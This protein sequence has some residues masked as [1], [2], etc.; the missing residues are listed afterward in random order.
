M[1]ERS[2]PREVDPHAPGGGDAAPVGAPEPPEPDGAGPETRVEVLD[3][4]ADRTEERP[5]A[6]H[7]AAADPT[8]GGER[9][10]GVSVA[11]NVLEW[12]TILGGALVVA[13]V[14]TRF[15]V[16]AFFIPSLSMYPAL[17]EGDRV[18]V[19]KL[20][21]RLHEINRGDLIVFERP[22]EETPGQVK[23]LIKR[24][25]ALEGERIEARGGQVLVDGEPLAEPYL[26]PGERTTNLEPLVVPEGHV[27]VMGDNRQDSRDS[28]F[29]GPLPEDLV[30]GRA[31]VK[32]WP[33]DD[34]ELL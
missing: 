24:V 15:L 33:V 22:A 13:L 20:S 17:E 12:L 27:F 21:Y 14:V 5:G 18:L 1:S 2:E 6:G 11:R 19:N 23:D 10:G 3:P 26:P 34:L 28:R 25:V 30:I 9:S 7:L 16:Q 32:V 4:K 31:F 29:F 8:A